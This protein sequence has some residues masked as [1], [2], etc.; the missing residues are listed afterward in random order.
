MDDQAARELQEALEAHRQQRLQ[1]PPL[2]SS[3]TDQVQWED[4]EG[5]PKNSVDSP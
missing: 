3:G 2:E 1:A 5:Q 4:V